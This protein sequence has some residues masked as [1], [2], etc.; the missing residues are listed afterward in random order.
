MAAISPCVIILVPMLL[1][2]V[3]GMKGKKAIQI[4]LLLLGFLTCFVII[5]FFLKQLM[6]SSFQSG[7]RLGLG[8]IFVALGCQSFFGKVGSLTF[9]LFD[10]PFLMG[11]VFAVLVS[12][13]PCTIPY[14]GMLVSLFAGPTLIPMMLVFAFGMI[15]PS[16]LFALF[17]SGILNYIQNKT[18]GAFHWINKV[19]ALVNI[20]SGLYLSF[21]IHSLTY[22][23]IAVAGV[24]LAASFGLL[25]RSY[26]RKENLLPRKKVSS[27]PLPEL[28]EYEKKERRNTMLIV[29]IFTLLVGLACAVSVMGVCK[30]DD[31][32][33]SKEEKELM[34]FVKSQAAER[35]ANK[36]NDEEDDIK[37]DDDEGPTDDDSEDSLSEINEDEEDSSA[38]SESK[39]KDDEEK[40]KEM[41]SALPCKVLPPCPQCKL[42]FIAFLVAF[43]TGFGS[44]LLLATKKE[45]FS[46][47]VGDV[48]TVPKFRRAAAPKPQQKQPEKSSAPAAKEAKAAPVVVAQVEQVK[49]T[50]AEKKAEAKAG[51]GKSKSTSSE[52]KQKSK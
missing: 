42:C 32:F 45:D 6:E 24:L 41:P 14:L 19:M 50:G 31:W 26:F 38:S 13:N 46:G 47:V 20:G 23:D 49:E 7:F 1:S 29:I 35:E 22:V 30:R 18:S 44:T 34:E 37:D 33:M 9:P 48:C 43:C 51:K 40:E 36:E 27:E 17:G 10:N 11:G 12:Y 15:T 2:K 4:P 28:S 16:F 5:G 3:N 25:F 8:L 52:K 21:S 39:E